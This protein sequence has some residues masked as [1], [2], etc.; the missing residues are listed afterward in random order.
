MTK[1]QT[2]PRPGI[3]VGPFRAIDAAHAAAERVLPE[4][5]TSRYPA[6]PIE[7]AEVIR[8]VRRKLRLPAVRSI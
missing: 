8:P 4:A 1:P 5:D 6:C 2:N 3:P 7:R